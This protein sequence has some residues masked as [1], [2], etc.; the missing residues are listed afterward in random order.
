MTNGALGVFSGKGQWG[1]TTQRFGCHPSLN[2]WHV[3]WRKS[4]KDQ[5][6]LFFVVF[7]WPLI[8][9]WGE[10]E[11]RIFNFYAGLDLLVSFLIVYLV[12]AVLYACLFD[13]CCFW[14]VAETS[15]HL[16]R[17]WLK[18]WREAKIQEFLG[19]KM[20][21]NN[22]NNCQTLHTFVLRIK[23]LVCTTGFYGVFEVS[24]WL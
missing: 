2:R 9:S 23:L 18:F 16:M 24:F 1:K 15:W 21:S 5:W 11:M 10:K 8:I 3:E 22:Y 17:L 20:F 7:F 12:C 14:T 19:Q 6:V 4:E 13:Y